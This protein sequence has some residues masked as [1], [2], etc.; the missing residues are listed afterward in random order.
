MASILDILANSNPVSAAVGGVVSVIGK[1][2]DKV[3]PDPQA[4]AAAALELLKLQQSG[5]LAQMAAETQLAQGQM[6][7]NK[8]EAASDGVFKGGWRPFVG[9]VGGIGLLYSVLLQP[10]LVWL[11][12]VLHFPSTPPILDTSVLMT[13]L[14]GMLGLGGMRTY[15]RV[16]K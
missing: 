13:I 4:K 15:E 3:I 5:E 2:L 1:V 9:W 6:E 7:I 8:V 10:L 12:P 11:T 16:K 14:G